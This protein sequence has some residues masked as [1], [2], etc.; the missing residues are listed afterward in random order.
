MSR[1][2]VGTCGFYKR[3][4]EFFRTFSLIEIQKTFYQP[5]QLKTAQRWR[6]EAPEEFEFTLKAWQ[7]I[8]HHGS[9]PTF[10]RSKL[11]ES[12]RAECG[13]FRNTKTVRNA[14]KAT[15]E[16]AE[17]LEATFVIFQC[18]KRFRP[19]EENVANMRKFFRWAKRG[20]LKIGWEPRGSEWPRTTI[21]ELC[22]ELKLIHV[23]DPFHVKRC[24]GT[25][26][27][28]RLH[29][30]VT[31]RGRID[32]K[33]RYT[34]T[35]LRKLAEMCTARTTYC[36]FNNDSMGDDAQRFERLVGQRAGQGPAAKQ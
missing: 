5:P 8:T 4:A 30:R 7:A 33:Y 32:Y 25:P 16:I 13:A 35:E 15:L 9:S 11:S 2:C 24:Y 3:Q 20:G 29:G 17:A 12:E 26:A 31:E 27:Y 36:L 1:I 28:Y 21:K 34:N 14:W 18:P 6:E 10:R 22:R 19:T 23:V